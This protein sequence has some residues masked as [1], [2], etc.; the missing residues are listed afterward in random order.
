MESKLELYKNYKG[1]GILFYKE[2]KIADI[3]KLIFSYNKHCANKYNT[4]ISNPLNSD[5]LKN[6]NGKIKIGE[7]MPDFLAMRRGTYQPKAKFTETLDHNLLR[8]DIVF[9]H[10]NKTESITLTMPDF[11]N[12]TH[13]MCFENLDDVKFCCST[14]EN[15]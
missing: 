11:P 10:N 7:M 14:T 5:T 4:E 15:D 12:L 8:L 13:K 6:L 9:T 1:T 3:S 2:Q